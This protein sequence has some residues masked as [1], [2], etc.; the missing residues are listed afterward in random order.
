MVNSLLKFYKT[1]P[2]H[3]FYFCFIFQGD[4]KSQKEAVWAVTN[5]TS[6]GSIEQISYLVSIQVI[7]PLCDLLCV[8]E[9]KVILVILDA[10]HNILMVI[11]TYF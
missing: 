7:P 10:I 5:L 3:F 11:I 6:G 1:L 9:A 2:A 4:Y 8:K